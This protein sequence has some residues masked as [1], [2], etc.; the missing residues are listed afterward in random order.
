M[1]K[2][3]PM[4]GKKTPM[5]GRDFGLLTVRK[6]KVKQTEAIIKGNDTS[7]NF[8]RMNHDKLIKIAQGT[9]L[10]QMRAL[11]RWFAQTNGMY[12][13]A[14]RYI[15]DVYKFDFLLYP[16]LDLDDEL[17]DEKQKSILK[18]FNAVLEH[19][20]NSAIQLM[21]RKWAMTVCLDGA[22]YGYICDDIGD[23]LV[24]QDLPTNFCRSRFY[25][26]GVPLV[27][28]NVQYFDK[29]TSNEHSRKQILSLF[30]EEFQVAYRKY[31][32][33]KLPA[34]EQGDDAGW[35]LLDIHRAFK[36]NFND[37]DIPPFMSAI[38]ALIELSEV[39]DLE[40]EKLLQQIQK[41]L[42]QHFDLDKNGQIPF[43]MQEL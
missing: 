12:N 32:A 42:I 31:K 34:E 39:Q 5:V 26:R 6:M 8:A 14:V 23:R 28:F 22:Y 33:G 36:F 24:I 18:K 4:G 19:F 2:Q 11:S 25:H 37:Q 9:D 41:V 3:P 29:I 43:T 21:S 38:P 1:A 35:V 16:N 40:K 17:A 13:R 7:N 20:D 27:E 10:Q 30:P 15:S